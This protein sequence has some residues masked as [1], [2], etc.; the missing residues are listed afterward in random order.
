MRVRG[1]PLLGSPTHWITL[2]LQSRPADDQWQPRCAPSDQ[3]P[4]PPLPPP[5]P[6]RCLQAAAPRPA[7]CARLVVLAAEGAAAAAEAK[8][9]TKSS[10]KIADN[11]TEVIGAPGCAAWGRF[12]AQICGGAVRAATAVCLLIH[13]LYA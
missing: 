13:S 12:V 5:P 4:S 7:R 3:L 8:P 1:A 10:K 6:T 11:I 2:K 9:V